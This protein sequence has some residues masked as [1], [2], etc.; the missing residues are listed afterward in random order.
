[1]IKFE[2]TFINTKTD[3]DKFTDILNTVF[4]NDYGYTLHDCKEY[5]SGYHSTLVCK[6]DETIIGGISAYI[7]DPHRKDKLPLERRGINLK[8]YVNLKNM[9]YA[10]ICR[11]GVLREFRKYHIYSE[12]MKRCV[13][14]VSE[15]D[16]K[17]AFGS[18]RDTIHNS[19]HPN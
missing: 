3:Q 19:I 10:E 14:F 16:V 12:L 8:T 7:S 1:M 11:A 17:E 4:Q 5:Y 15:S 6:Q 2:Y 18:L 9:R 13:N